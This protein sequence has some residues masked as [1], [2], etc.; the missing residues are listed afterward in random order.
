GNTDEST[1]LKSGMDVGGIAGFSKG[2]ILRCTNKG[3]IGYEHVGYNIGGIVGR[4]MGIVSYSTNEGNVYGRKDI[5]GIVGQMEPYLEPEDLQ[6]LPEAAD[7][8]HDLVD[9]T[10]NDMDGSVD[11]ISTDITDLTGYAD[12]VVDDGRVLT[13]ELT[14]S[15]NAN[16]GVLNEMLARIEYVMDSLPAVIDNISTANESLGYFNQAVARAVD[17]IGTDDELNEEDREIINQSENDMYTGLQSARETADQIEELTNKINALMY[18]TDSNGDYIYNEDGTRQVNTLSDENQALLNSYLAELQQITSDSGGQVS[19]MLGS[20]STI[21]E[22]YK[23]YADASTDAAIGDIN[24]AVS[25]LQSAQGSFNEAGKSA[26]SILDYLNAQSDLR[27]S[28][29]SSTWDNSLD[30]LHD[31]LKGITGSLENIN[32]DGKQSS[33]TL[34][35][36]L[37]AVNDQVNVI[38]HILSD[39]L[40]IIVNDDAEI[41]TDVSDEDIEQARTGRVDSSKNTGTIEGDI[42]IGGIAGSMAIDEDDPEEN[43]AG[44]IDIGSGSKYILKNIICD[45]SND[46]TVQ[47]KKDGAGLIVGY[48]A[49]GIVTSCI[50]SGKV[51]STEGSYTGGIAGESLSIIRDSNALCLI[52]G[53]KY[54]GGITGYGT[55]VSGCLAIATWENEPEERFGA[56]AGS[57]NTDSETQ[58]VKITNITNNYFLE[59]DIAGIDNISYT[60]IAE[61]LSY[62]SIINHDGAP[63]DF[64]HLRVSFEV[65]DERLGQQEL[66]YGESLSEIEFPEGE[67][68]EGYYIEWPDVSDLVMNGNYVISG[69]YKIT[70]KSVESSDTYENT[71]K[72]IALLGGSYGNDAQISAKI[73][74]EPSYKEVNPFTE[75]DYKVYKVEISEGKISQSSDKKIRLYN[76]YNKALVKEYI[77]GEWALIESTQ[78]GSYLEIP[79]DKNEGIY[80]VVEYNSTPLK[81]TC[82]VLFGIFLLVLFIIRKII[83]RWIR[84]I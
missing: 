74:D 20:V 63:S 66:K 68:K 47:S 80:A 40:D 7:T 30:S 24:D 75:H 56:I 2:S 12:G 28:G 70:K 15:V 69:E 48:M 64:R 82:A 81:I 16:V 46:S 43:A 1:I 60:G 67:Y 54:A 36:D 77:D 42:N 17:A 83:K 3:I 38:Y 52:D 23:P 11:S 53:K 19:G 65:D 71:G 6:T 37:E 62:T 22:T 76:P 25:A 79:M 14:T 72:T 34:N 4:Q 29:L 78:I 8:L 39:R 10:I 51:A 26:R 13:G 84:K 5:G 18:A 73:V 61:P 45:C 35:D 58:K 50:G 49:H 59:G 33:H 41:F 55:T 31:N 21:L 9:K 27:L 44:N 32:Q 57:V